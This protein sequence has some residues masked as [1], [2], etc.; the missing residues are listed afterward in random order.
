MRRITLPPAVTRL[1]ALPARWAPLFRRVLG[2]PRRF[3]GRTPAWLRRGAAVLLVALAGV[4]LGVQLGGHTSHDVGPFR[5]D[6]AIEPSLT[7]DANVQIPPLGAITV[8]SHDGPAELT[9]RIR[10]LDEQRTR[11]LINDPKQ[12]DAAS[13]DAATDIAAAVKELAF[14]ATLAAITGALLLGLVVFRNVRRA[15]F[16]ALTAFG[17]VVAVV[18]TSV[19]TY[20]PESIR[21]PRYE[22][23]L[24]NVPAVIGDAHN[25]Y[26][27]YGEYRGELIRIVTNMSRVYTNISS[28]PVYQPDPNTIRALH[29]TDLHLN[30]T[31]YQVIGAIA[32]QFQVNVIADTGD[33]TDWGSS[34]ENGYAESIGKL[35]VPYVFVRGN[36]DS[37]VTAAAVAKQP[38]AVVLDN[39][40]RKVAGL[41]FAGIGDPRFTPDKTG[42][43]LGPDK[44]LVVRAGEHLAEAVTT[45]N[46][47]NA[48]IPAESSPPAKN[49]TAGTADDGKVDLMLV[50]DPR[51]AEALVNA[52]P[53]VLAGHTHK[54]KISKLD[55]DTTLMVEGSTGARGLRGI[56]EKYPTPLQMTVLYF[57]PTGELQAYD[58]ITVSGAGQS[59]IE[60]ERTLV[61]P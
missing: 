43:D 30:P 58:E 13:D 45:Y 39:N 59:K 15:A 10:L 61:Q 41:T 9:A 20:T 54:R 48:T 37:P 11:E 51:A 31:S 22:G 40:V 27:R 47:Q 8:D 26:D 1:A 24:T 28:L 18:G 53:L 60:L 7:G 14:N 34:L 55:D 5:V 25:I 46:D 21:E 12:I 6:F 42:N 23:L 57:S 56:G 3:F 50:H 17:V 19:A 52:G 29:I 32:D 44:D 35:G 36:H 4:V 38:N 2:P 16:T 33:L 49:G